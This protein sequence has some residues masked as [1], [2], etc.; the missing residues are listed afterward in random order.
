MIYLAPHSLAICMLKVFPNWLFEYW[1]Y[2]KV[3]D[4]LPPNPS[5]HW[6]KV[7]LCRLGWP[8]THR[9]P[10]ASASVS[11]SWVLKWKMYVATP[12]H[13]CSS[14]NWKWLLLFPWLGVF[15]ASR[16]GW[17]DLQCPQLS[18]HP[19]SFTHQLYECKKLAQ[20][21]LYVLLQNANPNESNQ[22]SLHLQPPHGR[23]ANFS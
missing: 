20:A 4:V 19:D 21:L 12:S 13:C 2:F 10:P 6:A 17:S 22:C 3:A 1:K 7:S 8:W 5:F 14:F 11:A 15:R 9:D 16:W 18:P 23:D